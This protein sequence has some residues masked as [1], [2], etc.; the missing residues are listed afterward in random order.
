MN[1]QPQTIPSRTTGWIQ[2]LS[3]ALGAIVWVS[4]L[5]FSRF[6]PSFCCV[7]LLEGNTAQWNGVLPDLY[8]AE[9]RASTLSIGLH[10]AAGGIILVLIL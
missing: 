5:L 7:V 10:F 8:E 2:C 4:A 1:C 9:E 6:I 3:T